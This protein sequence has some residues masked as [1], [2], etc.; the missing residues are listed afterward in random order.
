MAYWYVCYAIGTRKVMEPSADERH[1]IDAACGLLRRGRNVLEVG[2][3]LDDARTVSSAEI[4]R[5]WEDRSK[6]H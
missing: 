2:S 1:A 5:I 6:R 3:M 4:R